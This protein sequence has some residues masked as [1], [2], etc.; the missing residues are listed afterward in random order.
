MRDKKMEVIINRS[1]ASYG[2]RTWV[3]PQKKGTVRTHK[4]DLCEETPVLI[5]EYFLIWVGVF[6]VESLLHFCTIME[7]RSASEVRQFGKADHH[8]RSR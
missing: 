8:T 7:L 2:N 1:P 3:L 6:G 5:M 4:H